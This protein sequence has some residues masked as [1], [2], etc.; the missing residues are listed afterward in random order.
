[1]FRAPYIPLLFL[2]ALFLSLGI[3]AQFYD[4]FSLQCIAGLFL[5]SLILTSSR[6]NKKHILPFVCCIATFCVG[7]F[8]LHTQ[9]KSHNTVYYALTS[10]AFSAQGTIIDIQKQ[11]HTKLAYR[12][13]V[14][15]E[16]YKTK[17]TDWQDISTK[18]VLNTSSPETW[19][20]NSGICVGDVVILHNLFAI[21]TDESFLLYLMRE[22]IGVYIFCPT[23]CITVVSRSA[24][25]HCR[26]IHQLRMETEEKLN[27]KFSSCVRIL[28]AALFLGKKIRHVQSNN[29]LPDHFRQWGISHLLARSG[30]HLS[31]FIFVCFLLFRMMPVP[32]ILKYFFSLIVCSIYFLLSYTSLS[33]E[34]ALITALFFFIFQLIKRPTNLLHTTTLAFIYFLITNPIAL[35]FLD[36]QLSFLF[37][38]TLAWL[39]QYQKKLI[40]K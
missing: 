4:L 37:T 3:V 32:L 18:I 20:K 31:I 29:D 15:I 24:Y 39:I 9:K 34:R 33:F 8:L 21:R 40:I 13:T 19:A 14:R 23:P 30:M 1:M 10:G 12:I 28:F 2:T 38:A 16:K 7:A 5:L 35:F 22:S 27:Q 6:V 26:F 11:G 25:S 17:K 36:F